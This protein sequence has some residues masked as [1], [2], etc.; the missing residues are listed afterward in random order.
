VET[1]KAAAYRWYRRAAA[2]RGVYRV[3]AGQEAE[4]LKKVLSPKAREKAEAW[5]A[6]WRAEGIWTREY[7]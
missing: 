7:R 3:T 1:D 2:S 5:V 6:D 4:R